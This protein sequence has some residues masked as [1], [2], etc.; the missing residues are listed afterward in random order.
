MVMVMA[1]WSG[2]NGC[3]II[4]IPPHI[5]ICIRIQMRFFHLDFI[6]TS[7]LE[8]ELTHLHHVVLPVVSRKLITSN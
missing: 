8:R 2:F 6:A 5:G 7:S 4:L 1:S 3:R